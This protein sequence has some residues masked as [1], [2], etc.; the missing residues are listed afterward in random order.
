[1]HSYI[2]ILSPIY[3]CFYFPSSFTFTSYLFDVP[4]LYVRHV[5][6]C[7]MIFA[8]AVPSA[9]ISLSLSALTH[10]SALVL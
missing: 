3:P 5:H 4:Q 10:I 2:L 9:G 6:S 1:M 8:R 7:L